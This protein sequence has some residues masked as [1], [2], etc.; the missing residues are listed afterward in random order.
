MPLDNPRVGWRSDMM[1]SGLWD[2]FGGI[3]L[4]FPSRLQDDCHST[5]RCG[6]THQCSRIGRKW[7]HG[8]S[9][10]L[11]LFYQTLTHTHT[12]IFP[13]YSAGFLLY[14]NGKLESMSRFLL[15]GRL[16]S[17]IAFS[18]FGGE[19]AMPTRRRSTEQTRGSGPMDQLGTRCRVEEAGLHLTRRCCHSCSLP[20]SSFCGPHTLDHSW[21]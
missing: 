12:H 9:S 21:E 17:K 18:S 7:G 10:C 4:T 11:S 2:G 5:K 6:L 1:M 20:P 13:R 3:L 15:Q 8:L 19:K 14:S 16:K